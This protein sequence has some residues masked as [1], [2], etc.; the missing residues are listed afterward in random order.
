MGCGAVGYH[1]YCVQESEER[2]YPFL[3]DSKCL[4]A[5]SLPSKWAIPAAGAVESNS[6]PPQGIVKG[7]PGPPLPS[8]P[9]QQ[10][11]ENKMV[12]PPLNKQVD[13]RSPE[14]GQKSSKDISQGLPIQKEAES[15]SPG[16]KRRLVEL[17]KDKQGSKEANKGS[18]GG[19]DGD[20]RR[21]SRQAST[22]IAKTPFPCRDGDARRSSRQASSAVAETPFPGKSSLTH[23]QLLMP[24]S[25]TL[26][27][28]PQELLDEDDGEGNFQAPVPVCSPPRLIR[29]TPPSYRKR[30]QES[31]CEVASETGLSQFGRDIGAGGLADEEVPNFEG[32][33][34]Q[35]NALNFKRSSK[36]QWQLKQM[37]PPP[38]PPL[39][40]AGFAEAEVKSHLI[41][42]CNREKGFSELSVACT[43]I[44][45]S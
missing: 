40:T 43:Y 31:E 9:A 39:P 44:D 18:E 12:V 10:H 5:K 36:T 37:T 28:L 38:L 8:L 25:G 41:P 15:K 23:G 20:K 45:L 2:E 13:K 11:G 14:K 4:A 16:S 33:S 1:R 17:T 6:G 32:Y 42:A 24:E 35:S 30:S 3:A 19:R 22:A 29:T 27:P 26:M 21:S 34:M 7:Q